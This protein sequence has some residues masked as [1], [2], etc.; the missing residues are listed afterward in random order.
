MQSGDREASL[1]MVSKVCIRVPEDKC[2]LLASLS[3]VARGPESLVDC[4]RHIIG[5]KVIG[6]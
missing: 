1:L 2:N 4:M 6:R 5:A 3:L